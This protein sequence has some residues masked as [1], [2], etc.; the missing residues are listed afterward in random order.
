[1]YSLSNFVY[2]VQSFSLS[3]F[4]S[5]SQETISSQFLKLHGEVHS[6]LVPTGPNPQSPIIFKSD[7]FI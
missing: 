4:F 7:Y 6:S 5:A 2:A 1:M 3:Y